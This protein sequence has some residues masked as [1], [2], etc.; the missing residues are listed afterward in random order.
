MIRPF[1]LMVHLLLRESLF[2]ATSGCLFVVFLMSESPPEIKVTKHPE[3]RIVSA[4]GVF[5][6]LNPVEGQ[7]IF[8]TDRLEPKS[9]AFGNM[10]LGFVN[11][12]LQVEVH[13]S[14]ASFKSIADFMTSR[15]KMF[16]EQQKQEIAAVKMGQPPGTV[17]T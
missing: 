3:C 16:E 12:E 4:S 10:S 5:G 13:F 8:Y 15:V 1:V 2:F 6:G 17:Y 7:L 9:D 11:R 14:P